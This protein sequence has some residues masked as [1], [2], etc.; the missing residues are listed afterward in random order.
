MEAVGRFDYPKK[1]IVTIKRFDAPKNKFSYANIDPELIAK[2]DKEDYDNY[3]NF[4][5]HN[6]YFDNNL[7][8]LTQRYT[9][10][11]LRIHRDLLYYKEWNVKHQDLFKE[12]AEL[13]K[14]L[15]CYKE[16]EVVRTRR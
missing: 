10:I 12:I 5:S 3:I 1:D 11:S 16:I 6:N 4:L 14:L 13:E 8:N 2:G 15:S 9:D 7:D